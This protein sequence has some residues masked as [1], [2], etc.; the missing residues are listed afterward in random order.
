MNFQ[1]VSQIRVP[2]GV[3]E[4]QFSHMRGFLYDLGEVLFNIFFSTA[5]Y[6]SELGLIGFFQRSLV[7]I[8][9]ILFHFNLR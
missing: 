6:P 4:K 5:H 9:A 2:V 7:V 1:L 3:R 8:P